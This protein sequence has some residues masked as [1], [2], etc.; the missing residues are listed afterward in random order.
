[1]SNIKTYKFKQITY[2]E[3]IWVNAEGL[4]VYNEHPATNRSIHP[5]NPYVR[6]H[7]FEWN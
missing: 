3:E 4:Q 5:N 2:F 7:L 1:M 6:W